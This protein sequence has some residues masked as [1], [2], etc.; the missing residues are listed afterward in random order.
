MKL[1]F[2]GI[3]FFTAVNFLVFSSDQDFDASSKFQNL[4]E[5]EIYT[6]YVEVLGNIDRFSKED[7]A[8]IMTSLEEDVF[9]AKKVKEILR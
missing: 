3:L 1:L 5:S 9:F 8:R 2:N 6:D 7:K 4:S